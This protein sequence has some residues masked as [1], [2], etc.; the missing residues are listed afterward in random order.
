LFASSSFSS[1]LETPL[2]PPPKI[3]SSASGGLGRNCSLGQIF[4]NIS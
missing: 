1:L 3:I 2:S 4:S